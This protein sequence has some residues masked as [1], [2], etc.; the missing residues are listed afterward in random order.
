MMTEMIGDGMVSSLEFRFGPA[1]RDR[2]KHCGQILLM[3]QVLIDG[4]LARPFGRR[5]SQPYRKNSRGPLGA[6]T[7]CASAAAL[8]YR[9]ARDARMPNYAV[10][11]KYAVPPVSG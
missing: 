4:D 8:P 5:T 3:P 2:D 6:P 10:R 7:V 11:S 1:V 9:L